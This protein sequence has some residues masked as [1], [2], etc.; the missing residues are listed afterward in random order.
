M[1]IL[2][3]LALKKHFSNRMNIDLTVHVGSAQVSAAD[4]EQELQFAS[5]EFD[6][7]VAHELKTFVDGEIAVSLGLVMM[8]GFL[9][10]LLYHLLT[11]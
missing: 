6:H 11:S 2:Q 9:L 10:F 7:T 8:C 1:S 5:R 3:D 4:G